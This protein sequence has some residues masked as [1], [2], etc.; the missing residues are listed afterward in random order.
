M[1]SLDE[2]VSGLANFGRRSHPDKILTFGWLATRIDGRDRFDLEDV[3]RSY[4]LAHV[5]PCA[6]LSKEMARLLERGALLRD[7]RGYFLE[8]TTRDRL[9]TEFA[10]LVPRTEPP[11]ADRAGVSAAP[12]LRPDDLQAARRMAELY[13]VLHCFENSARQLITEVLG[14]HLGVDWW[15]KSSSKEMERKVVDRR[16]K[17][18]KNRWLSPRGNSP[19][20]YLDWGDLVTLI[21]KFENLFDPHVGELKFIAHELDKLEALRNVVAHHGTLPSEDDFQRVV[22]AFRDWCRQVRS[23]V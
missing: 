15:S 8:R 17:E 21:R 13:L 6:N 20:F 1:P 5:R 4:E 19:L 9:D 14:K 22:L 2:M 16:A 7:E 23:V 12:L 10:T 11:L 3:R 18:M